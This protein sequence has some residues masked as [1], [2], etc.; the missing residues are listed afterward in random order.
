[1][2]TDDMTDGS[3]IDAVINR[4][5]SAPARMVFDQWI[6]VD[7]LRAWFAPAGFDVTFAETDPVPGGKWQV[8]MRS[9]DGAVYLEYGEYREIVPAKR[10]VFTLTQGHDADIA[11]RTTVTVDFSDKGDRTEIAFLQEGFETVERR[12][13]NIGGWQ[14][15]FDNLAVRLVSIST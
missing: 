15:C 3:N 1:M 8:E 12:D 13:S 7:G 6:T 9:P 14:E 4:S 10:L 5:F 2:R 11:P